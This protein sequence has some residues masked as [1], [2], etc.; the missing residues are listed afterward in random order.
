[1]SER[2][3]IQLLV[4]DIDGTLLNSRLELSERNRAALQ[5]A[6]TQGVQVVLATGKTRYAGQR[7]ID[8]LGLH[9]HGIFLQGLLITD[10]A[11]NVIHQTLLD[12]EVVRQVVTFA[13]DRGF[14]ALAYSG[15]HIYARRNEPQ[16]F[17]AITRYH[18]A[19]PEVVGPLQNLAGE[20]AIHKIVMVG[21]EK[22]IRALRWQ[23]NKIL[24]G[25]AR[26]VHAGI[27]N[28]LEVLPPAG[29]K[30][31]ALR[32]LL[33][34]LKVDARRVMAIGDAE[35]DIEMLQV[36]GIGVAMGQA[37]QPVKDIAQFVTGTNDEDGVAQAIERNILP[38]A[39]AEASAP[40]VDGHQD[41]AKSAAEPAGEP[42]GET[43][44]GGEK[45]ND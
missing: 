7:M 18:D 40:T 37:A 16:V 19:E 41:A 13:E 34:H 3:S 24:G 9:T 21:D 23:L 29:G 1:M 32:W 26:L 45:A 11:G 14:V 6:M 5:K 4:V 44:S 8:A 38:P 28:M 2:A 30:G 20:A 42:V 15:E 36:A 39:P 17:A 10:G 25:T 33:N 35:N 27:P 22:Q 12:P 31:P 43:A